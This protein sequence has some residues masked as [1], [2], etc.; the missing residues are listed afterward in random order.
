MARR[1]CKVEGCEKIV[2]GHGLCPTHYAR[3][4]RNGDPLAYQ[5]APNGAAEAFIRGNVGYDSPECLEW[6]YG[7]ASNGYGSLVLDGQGTTAHRAMCVAAH[8][9]PPFA[10]AE[11]AHSCGNRKCVSPKHLRWA[12]GTENNH[13][14]DE[15][16][17]RCKGEDVHNAKLSEAA[18][19]VI[20]ASKDSH[21]ALAR[22]FGV[23]R[24]AIRKVRNGRAWKHVA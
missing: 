22:Q 13:D 12:T 1:I 24:A 21:T 16:G 19:P 20:R 2:N 7:F 18:I 23:S 9:P 10:D 6:P 8:G 5:R 14:M 4:K 11:A 15:H 17:T 3:W